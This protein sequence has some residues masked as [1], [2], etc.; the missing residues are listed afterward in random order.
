[1]AASYTSQGSVS[2]ALARPG[3]GRNSLARCSEPRQQWLDAVWQG[4]LA[5]RAVQLSLFYLWVVSF[6]RVERIPSSAALFQ[7]FDSQR[8]GGGLRTPDQWLI[9]ANNSDKIR[10]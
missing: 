8:C 4:E 7:V 2:E 5:S 6:F 1:M 10:D 9:M 3:E